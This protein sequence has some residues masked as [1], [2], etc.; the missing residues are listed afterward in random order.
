MAQTVLLH[1]VLH[2]T[3]YEVDGSWLVVAASSSARLGGG[4][5]TQV[6]SNFHGYMA[7]VFRPAKWLAHSPKIHVKLR[8]SSVNK[9]PNWSRGIRSPEFP[10]FPY[11]F[12]TQRKGCRVTL[13][14]DAHVPDN[15][16][17]KIPLAGAKCYEPHRCWE[18]VLMPFLCKALIIAG[19]SVCLQSTPFGLLRDPKRAQS[20]ERMISTLWE[21]PSS[22]VR[23]AIG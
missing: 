20:T 15:F 6:T 21:R 13:Y 4:I 2:A 18:D 3:I 11:T 10:G 12:F 19:W 9:D 7:S 1:G 22:N 16:I 17:P 14:Q 8:F 5:D 23:R